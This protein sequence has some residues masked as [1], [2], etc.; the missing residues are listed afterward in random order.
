MSMRVISTAASFCDYDMLPAETK[1]I[2]MESGVISILM[3]PA[4]NHM[5]N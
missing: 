1:V 4:W 3:T 2:I 5:A